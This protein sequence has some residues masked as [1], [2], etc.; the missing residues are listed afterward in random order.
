MYE[1]IIPS[2]PKSGQTCR[3]A[4]I[5]SINQRLFWLYPPLIFIGEEKCQLFSIFV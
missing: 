3:R 1:R 2:N 5:N 4:S